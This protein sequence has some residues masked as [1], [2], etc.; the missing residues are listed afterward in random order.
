MTNASKTLGWGIR[1]RFLDRGQ[2]RRTA[3]ARDASPACQPNLAAGER[4]LVSPLRHVVVE[5]SRG[6]ALES[7]TS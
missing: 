4:R 3:F 1:L 7:P 5:R 6:M 2:L